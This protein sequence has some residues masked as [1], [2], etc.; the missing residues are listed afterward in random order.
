VDAS[1]LPYSVLVPLAIQL[2][3]L[4]VELRRSRH[5]KA[6]RPTP[7]AVSSPRSK[8]A[9]VAKYLMLGTD[10]SQTWRLPDDVEVSQLRATIRRARQDR[11]SISIKILSDG[12]ESDLDLDG[13][14]IT[15]FAVVEVPVRKAVGL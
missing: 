6:S 2:I 7:V 9:V 11:C 8:E 13:S 14:K 3:K 1:D 10:G 4:G 5:S 12:V 15:A